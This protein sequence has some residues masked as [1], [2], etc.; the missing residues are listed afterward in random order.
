MPSEKRSRT[1]Q[2]LTG[3]GNVYQGVNLIAKVRFSLTITREIMNSRSP[4]GTHEPPRLKDIRGVITILAGE[5]HLV[6]GSTLVLQLSDGSQWEFTTQSG[7]F[8]SGEYVAIGTG[9][10]D[11]ITD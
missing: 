4:S 5:R 8:I 3:I 2:T 7:N 9:R 10:Q 1:L 11:I 6:D